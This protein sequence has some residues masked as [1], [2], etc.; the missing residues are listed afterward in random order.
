[1]QMPMSVANL[2]ETLP[3]CMVHDMPEWAGGGNWRQFFFASMKTN[4]YIIHLIELVAIGL[5]SVEWFCR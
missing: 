2:G 1:M 4:K 3:A 5:K